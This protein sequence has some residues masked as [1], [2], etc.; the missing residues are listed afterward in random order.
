MSIT[1][2]ES[3]Y[4]FIKFTPIILIFWGIFYIISVENECGYMI[5][6]LNLDIFM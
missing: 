5:F 2:N 6:K 1:N 3:E 4:E